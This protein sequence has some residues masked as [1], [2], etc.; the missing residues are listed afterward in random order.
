[1]DVLVL[2]DQQE[3]C[4]DI[5][6]SQENLPGAKDDRERWREKVSEICAVSMT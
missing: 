4:A 3:L 2:A 5:R 1:M 6:C